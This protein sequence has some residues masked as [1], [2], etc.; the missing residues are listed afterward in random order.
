MINFIRRL[1]GIQIT[2]ED[3]AAHQPAPYKL[4]PQIS[5]VAE[6]PNQD[7]PPRAKKPAKKPAVRAKNAARGAAKK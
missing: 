2:A 6:A 3:P 7:S 4:E 1:F 5:P